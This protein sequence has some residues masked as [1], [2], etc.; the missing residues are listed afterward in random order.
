MALN[1]QIFQQLRKQAIRKKRCKIQQ[2]YK[3]NAT[4]L[5]SEREPKKQSSQ[6]H[7]NSQFDL[8]KQTYTQHEDALQKEQSDAPCNFI[9][10]YHLYLMEIALIKTKLRTK[11]S[12]NNQQ[13]PTARENRET[14][15]AER[16]EK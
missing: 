5:Y 16:A 13:Q 8:N 14:E 15:T 12:S 7:Y 3:E 6:S 1:T 10:L 11:L 9:K 2:R 4:R